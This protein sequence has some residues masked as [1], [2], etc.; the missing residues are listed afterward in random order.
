MATNKATYTTKYLQA[1]GWMTEE[2]AFFIGGSSQRERRSIITPTYNKINIQDDGHRF[3]LFEINL[4]L[5]FQVKKKS[6][7]M[8]KNKSLSDK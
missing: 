2:T 4:N 6:L 5:I 1:L 3:L 8:V 7:G